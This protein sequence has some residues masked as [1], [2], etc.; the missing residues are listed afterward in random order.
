M[1]QGIVLLSVYSA[2]LA[3]PFM[4]SGWS[5]EFLM[6]TMK[7]MRQY[8]GILEKAAG[9]LLIIVGCFM[10]A[11]VFVLLNIYATDLLGGLTE[12]VLAIEDW[13]VE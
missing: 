11:D 12:S 7:G 13:L 1:L 5:I 9:C 8:F 4:L 3:I 6:R 2:G 10:V